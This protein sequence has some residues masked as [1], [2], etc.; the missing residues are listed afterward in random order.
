MKAFHGN[1]NAVTTVSFYYPV[2]PST[3]RAKDITD[4]DAKQCPTDSLHMVC[5]QELLSH[6]SSKSL[7]NKADIYECTP[8]HVAAEKGYV[9][10]AEVVSCYYTDRHLV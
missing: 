9:V 10:V 2:T 1:G 4:V 7:I 5:I 3:N 6:A 8:L